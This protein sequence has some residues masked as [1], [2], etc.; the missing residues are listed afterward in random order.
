MKPHVVAV[1]V[2]IAVVVV[3]AVV[4]A[5][6]VVVYRTASTMIIKTSLN[7]LMKELKHRIPF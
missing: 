4:V 1:V 5:V 2:E 3:V 7:L 6:V